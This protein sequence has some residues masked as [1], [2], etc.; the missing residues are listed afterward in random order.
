MKSFKLGLM[1]L[2]LVSA[3]TTL[4]AD[5]AK[6]KCDAACAAD[7]GTCPVR[8]PANKN[9]PTNPLLGGTVGSRG[10]FLMAATPKGDLTL[11]YLV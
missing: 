4:R 8:Q 6:G 3:G 10:S 11:S 7:A 2:A 5:D 1:A 9:V